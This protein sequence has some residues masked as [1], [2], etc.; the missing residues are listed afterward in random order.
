MIE[1]ML[2]F[3]LMGLLILGMSIGVIVSNKP[4]KGTCGGMAALGVDTSCDICGGDTSLCD[5]QGTEPSEPSD[6]GYDAGR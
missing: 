4:I 2:A 1:L 6:L 3:L 5:E